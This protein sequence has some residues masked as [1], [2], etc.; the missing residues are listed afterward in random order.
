MIQRSFNMWENAFVS[1]KAGHLSEAQWARL[2]ASNLEWAK[3]RVPLSLWQDMQDGPWDPELFEM[4]DVA[5]R[6]D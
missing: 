6:E 5:Y 4:I 3:R 1:Y 2:H